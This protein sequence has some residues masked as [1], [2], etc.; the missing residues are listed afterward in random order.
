MKSSVAVWKKFIGAIE[1]VQDFDH[2][3]NFDDDPSDTEIIN[4]INEDLFLEDNP[5]NPSPDEPIDLTG[6]FNRLFDS[7]RTTDFFNTATLQLHDYDGESEKWLEGSQKC[8][9]KEVW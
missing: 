9:Y 6:D 5:T 8:R 4:L 7:P 2:G 3:P 1:A